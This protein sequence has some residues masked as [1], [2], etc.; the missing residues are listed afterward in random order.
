M[1]LV[2]SEEATRDLE[3]IHAYVA[4]DAPRRADLLVEEL[5][6]AAERLKTLP[7]S[8]RVVPE[9]AEP[10]IREV[11]HGSY[12]IVYEIVDD[13]VEILTVLHGAKILSDDLLS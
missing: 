2:W 7:K 6:E 1:K 8:G 10:A 3:Q 9:Y 12:R 13:A 5:L 4:R 11:I